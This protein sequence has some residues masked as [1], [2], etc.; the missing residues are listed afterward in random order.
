VRSKNQR[1]V[2]KTFVAG[3]IRAVAS[4]SERIAGFRG[5]MAEVHQTF[6]AGSIPAVASG[7]R[8]CEVSAEVSLSR[9]EVCGPEVCL[10]PSGRAVRAAPPSGTP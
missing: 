5:P 8:F 6:I 4:V 10:R 1:E 7:V 3:S 9:A 2:C